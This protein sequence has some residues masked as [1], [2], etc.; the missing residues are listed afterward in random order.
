MPTI[1]IRL[2]EIADAGLS[3]LRRASLLNFSAII[4]LL[5]AAVWIQQINSDAAG[6]AR[7]ALL[8]ETQRGL[9]S[10]VA[11]EIDLSRQAEIQRRFQA[12]SEELS[13]R[14]AESGLDILAEVA[15][16]RKHS[17][18]IFAF[19]AG[20]GQQQAVS[21]IDGP[22][23]AATDRIRERILERTARADDAVFRGVA[24]MFL[25]GVAALVLQFVL[26]RQSERRLIRRMEDLANSISNDLE[27]SAVSV[28]RVASGDLRPTTKP[29][30]RGTLETSRLQ[31]ALANMEER[32][33]AILGDL[34]AA[35]ESVSIGAQQVSASAHALSLGTARQ[36]ASMQ[37][38]TAS[39]HQMTSS[40]SQNAQL[41][42]TTEVLAAQNATGA[43]NGSDGVRDTVLAMRKV[44]EKATAVEDFA[45]QT[46]LLSLNAA[47]EAARA[48]EQG[49]GFAVVAA[50]VRN[51]SARSSATSRDIQLVAA[52]SIE[53]AER[54]SGLILDLVPASERTAVAANQVAG[55]SA[56]QQA[57]AHQIAR[58][59]GEID[60]VT[61]STAAASEELSATA[62]AIANQ[63][64]RLRE[65]ASFFRFA[66][67]T[68]A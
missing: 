44:I 21:V 35:A 55:V 7:L 2:R 39:V 8:A 6:A 65:S 13:A 14:A 34:Q 4:V 63:A 62:E 45:Y 48:G 66:T 54:A 28:E 49:R 19:A 46:H 33:V 52:S 18:E 42:R 51:L 26:G 22:F 12:V 16:A 31:S 40:I 53:I 29:F 36:A 59:I 10:R 41:S 58:A 17:D 1:R 68:A 9:V 64:R 27:D 61:Q 67:P 37:Q 3:S 43:R 56:E 15:L 60:A 30:Q 20:F 50:E 11:S 5:V 25:L 32:L 47:I 57:A 38:T 24:V 23:A